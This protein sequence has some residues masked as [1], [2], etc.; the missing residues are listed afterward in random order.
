MNSYSLDDFGKY[1]TLADA[2]ATFENAIAQILNNSG[3]QLSIPQSTH[4]NFT[5]QNLRQL[6]NPSNRLVVG[7]KPSSQP[8]VGVTVTDYRNGFNRLYLPPVGAPESETLFGNASQILERSV[9]QDLST[10]GSFKTQAIL[11]R[12]LGGG[13][14]YML[15]LL[16]PVSAGN[17]QKF[18][19]PTHRGLFP[20]QEL[21]IYGYFYAKIQELGIDDTGYYFTA[22]ASKDVAVGAGVYNK[23]ILGG[24]LIADTSNCDNQSPSLTIK[25]STYGTGDTFGLWSQLNYQGNIMSGGGDEGGVGVTSELIHDLDCFWGTVE[26]W[27]AVTHELIY[28]SSRTEN[29]TESPQNPHKLGTSRPLI[30]MNSSRWRTKGQVMII[31]AGFDYLRI[32]TL[33]EDPKRTRLS[34]SLIIG[35]SSNQWDESVVG[36]FFTID[37]ASEYYQEGEAYYH[38]DS[39][40]IKQ[41]TRRWWHITHLEKRSDG[42]FNLYVERVWWNDTDVV[43]GGPSLF[44]VDN[45]TFNE[46]NEKSLNYII[47]P[48]AWV[49]DVR[50]AVAVPSAGKVGLAEQT[51]KRII[52]LAPAA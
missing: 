20:G 37:D 38:A 31:G 14:S 3:G 23:N 39:G 42:R 25:R 19:I 27:N 16:Q 41:P 47:A 10:M 48:G 46:K 24:L 26:S 11:S 44:R 49:A 43:K 45:Y 51:M 4:E 21:V 8:N 18:Y 6:H 1:E 36:Q 7:E 15:S 50:D 2:E 35:E 29:S 17:S 5:P 33:Q 28:K 13:S 40:K 34:S 12:Y 30:N 32:G 9:S 52:R 22:D